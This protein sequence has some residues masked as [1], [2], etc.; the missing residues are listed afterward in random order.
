MD[1]LEL[2]N[3]HRS[4]DPEQV[5]ALSLK[6]RMQQEHAQ[7][8]R[9]LLSPLAGQLV[10]FK[11]KRAKL[12]VSCTPTTARLEIVEQERFEAR[13]KI[14]G[15]ELFEIRYRDG[16]KVMDGWEI[17]YDGKYWVKCPNQAAD[18][19]ASTTD[20]IAKH[21]AAQVGPMLYEPPEGK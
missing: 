7:E 6:R 2:A 15:E 13:A 11:G 14:A 21:I 16:K 20:D 8:C 9:I 12:Q 17:G 19:E 10:L 3:K 1:I 5:K 4:D 18:Y